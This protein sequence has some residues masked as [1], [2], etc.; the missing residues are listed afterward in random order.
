MHVLVVICR[1]VY[2]KMHRDI[3]PIEDNIYIVAK[4]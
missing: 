2:P 4:W 1:L 3:Y